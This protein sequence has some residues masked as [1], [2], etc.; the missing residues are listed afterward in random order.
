MAISAMKLKQFERA[1]IAAAKWYVN[2]QHR[3][4][5]PYWDANHGR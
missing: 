1:G 4:T 2:S 3:M 5:R